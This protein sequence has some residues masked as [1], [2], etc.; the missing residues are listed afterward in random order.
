MH[1]GK[2]PQKQSIAIAMS[3]AGLSRKKKKKSLHD[4]MKEA[5][6]KS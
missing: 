1:T 4:K 5:K 2:Y 6:M 3:E